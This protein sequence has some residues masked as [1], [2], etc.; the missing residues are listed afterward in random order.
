MLKEPNSTKVLHNP[1][2]RV[3]GCWAKDS[4]QKYSYAPAVY[5]TTLHTNVHTCTSKQSLPFP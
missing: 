5:P 4:V 1:S 2:E 3:K